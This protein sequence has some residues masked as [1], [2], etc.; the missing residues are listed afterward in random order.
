MGR[1]RERLVR[2]PEIRALALIEEAEHTLRNLEYEADGA[3]GSL[4]EALHLLREAGD[5]AARLEIERDSDSRTEWGRQLAA[6]RVR[7]PLA[8]ERF[9]LDATSRYAASL[10]LAALVHAGA[11]AFL[12][13]L[14]APDLRTRDEALL[15]L[16]LP[17]DL[18]IPQPPEAITK[19]ATPM[20]TAFEIEESVTIG[21]TTFEANPV[22]LHAPRMR[23]SEHSLADRP[24]F[25]AYT[26][27]PEL[28]NR[29]EVIYYL[30]ELYPQWARKARVRVSVL[31]YLF[32][33]EEGTVQRTVIVE[34]SGHDDFDDAAEEVAKQM[35]WT[36][37]LNRDRA[38]P[39]WL[40]Q[41]V[42]FAAGQPVVGGGTRLP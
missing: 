25:V 18:R 36:P 41:H 29:E 30:S 8:H 21:R 40:M 6:V 22:P 42:I 35:A 11:L 14:R 26:Q 16:D 2:R 7:R 10:I 3:D 5:A 38:T 27:A 20:V 31:L 15:A 12:P 34:S 24:T 1:V 19:P 33:N 17:P 37:A 13:G 23:E 4:R 32:I 28:T 9:K 39:V